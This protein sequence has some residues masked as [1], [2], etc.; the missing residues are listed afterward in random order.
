MNF[1][2]RN[3]RDIYKSSLDC[4]LRSCNNLYSNQDILFPDGKLQLL[5]AIEFAVPQMNFNSMTNFS[6]SSTFASINNRKTVDEL[7]DMMMIFQPD[8][9]LKLSDGSE[10]KANMKKLSE[11]SAVFTELFKP[12]NL[13]TCNGIVQVDI[14]R[15]TMIELMRYIYT[16]GMQQAT[17]DNITKGRMFIAACKYEM[18]ELADIYAQF[19]TPILSLSN[20][21]PIVPHVI[22]KNY[23]ELFNECCKIIS[24]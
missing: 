8:I 13:S 17:V 11:K 24:M 16:N 1:P 3:L 6:F 18:K 5:V 9:T 2:E 15:Q 21:L 22:Q 7:F 10:L 14:N 12:E 4:H 20:V 19:M 23:D